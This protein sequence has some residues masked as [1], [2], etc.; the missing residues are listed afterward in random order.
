LRKAKENEEED[1]KML[2][3]VESKN[4]LESMAY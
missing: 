3:K 4:G 2:E 1:K